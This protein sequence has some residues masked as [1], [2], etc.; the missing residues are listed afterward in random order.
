MKRLFL[1]LFAMVLAW[2]GA[3]AAGDIKP[4]K[5]GSWGE[6]LEDY[7]GRDVAVHF[8]SLGCAPCLA[9]MPRWAEFRKAAADVPLILIA[10][11]S[12]ERAARLKAVLG[13]YGLGDAETWAFADSF[14][15]R[16]LFEVDPDW[17][18]ELPMTR[19]VDRNGNVTSV[20]GSF[21]PWTIRET[22]RGKAGP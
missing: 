12:I 19:L 4:F 9:E 20:I 1:C 17:R 14:A 10:V 18:G 21:D 8:W 5:R 6:I 7:R 2:N 16:L 15:D 22:L 3:V 13:R 11:D